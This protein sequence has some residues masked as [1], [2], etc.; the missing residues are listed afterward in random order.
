MDAF[1][2]FRHY[3][4]YRRLQEKFEKIPKRIEE[5]H[6]FPHSGTVEKNS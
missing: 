3:A 6:F 5:F 4:T 1:Y 2:I